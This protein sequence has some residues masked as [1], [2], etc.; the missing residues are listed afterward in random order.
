[1]H[2]AR[3]RRDPDLRRDTGFRRDA[4][5][6]RG[7]GL[8]LR[9]ALLS[10]AGLP[11]MAATAAAQAAAGAPP[12]VSFTDVTAAAGISYSHATALGATKPYLILGGVAAGDYDGDGWVDLF[13]VRGTLGPDLLLRNR[14]DGTFE[15]VAAAAGVGRS[16]YAGSGPIFVD[17]DGD[18]HLDLLVGGVEAA[19]VALYRNRGDG[20]FED[21]SAVAAPSISGLV[22]GAAFGDI[23]G[24][25]DLDLFVSQ[26]SALPGDPLWRNDGGFQLTSVTA[27]A[28]GPAN[29]ALRY[30]FTPIFAD[31][32]D[33][34]ALDLL[35]TGDFGNSQVLANQGD[36]SFQLTTDPDVIIDENGMGA[37]VADFDGDGVLDW[38]VTSIFGAGRI[39]GNRLYRGLG[40]GQLADVTD[41]AGVAD[42]GWGW[43]A[44]A[45]DF[46]NDGDVD[47]F[48]VNGWVTP[49]FDADPS[50]LFVN[51]GDGTF[52]EAAAAWGI[53]DTRMGRGVV[54]FDYDRDGDLDIFIANL[55][56]QPRLLRNDGGARLPSLSVSLAGAS[57]NPFGIGARVEITGS[58][59][60]QLRLIRAGS[61]YV[62]QDPPV[63][64][65]GLGAAGSVD[66]VSVLW[67]EGIRST[68]SAP[69]GGELTIGVSLVFAAGFEAGTA[70]GWSPG[71]VP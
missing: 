23:D 71:A 61:N 33:D 20:G 9:C 24:D 16:H 2:H 4:A 10:C 67:P 51:A 54:C 5:F 14:G 49:P 38:F 11:L 3:F 52:S 18:G 17:I 36:G 58:A 42:G 31:L 69:V 60:S 48:H 40:G 28:L 12:S 57:P 32:D 39:Y 25:R 27:S 65:F 47:I 43:A 1:M 15:D 41:A 70:A 13:A 6:L 62:S 19:P 45:A 59:G 64:H 63:A 66:T 56:E 46:D 44:C 21:L 37:T 53:D 7:T 35:V 55:G 29:D 30:T 68:L 26:W 8:A 34:G 50:R 22:I